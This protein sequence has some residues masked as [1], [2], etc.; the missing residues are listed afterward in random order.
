M[1]P[2]ISCSFE[3][4]FPI[5]KDLFFSLK[6][7]D[8]LD[9]IGFVIPASL[10][11]LTPTEQHIIDL[12]LSTFGKYVAKNI[13]IMA[14]FCDGQKPPVIDA[15]KVSDIP[16]SAFF[17]FN[18]SAVYADKAHSYHSDSDDVSF[19]EMFWRMVM[20]SMK[21]F[22]TTLQTTA[23]VSLVMTR[24]V[25]N[26]REKLN[27]TIKWLSTVIRECLVQ[28]DN[29]RCKKCILMDYEAK[30]LACTWQ[31]KAPCYEHLGPG[32]QEVRYRTEV[33]T[34]EPIRE[35]Y[36]DARSSK[37]RA[38]ALVH[39]CEA[40]LERDYAN[41]CSLKEEARQYYFNDY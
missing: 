16:H 20:Q 10:V 8:H 24:N 40:Q 33:N 21:K 35:R 9:C 12:M 25:L 22:F 39:N 1:S 37:L 5:I 18:N 29:L 34:F 26:Q 17:K 32:Q 13:F 15:L 30:L 28:M 38:E 6:V 27:A 11:K 7:I 14:T 23:S 3:G 4:S 31:V 41:L 36:D 19:D 2:H